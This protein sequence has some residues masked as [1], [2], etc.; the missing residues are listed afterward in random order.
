MCRPF[1]MIITPNDTLFN[2]KTNSH[3]DLIKEH[4]LKDDSKKPNFVRVEITPKDGDLFNHNLDNWVMRVDQ[5]FKPAWWKNK[6]KHEKHLKC[7]LEK[8]IFP[9]RFAINE[10]GKEFENA[11]VWIKN[12]KGIIVRNSS[13]VAW[14]NSS[15]VARGNS[16]VVAWENSS[17]VACVNSSVVAWENSSVVAWENSSVEARGNSSVVARE[18]SSVEAN[19]FSMIAV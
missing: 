17:V 11:S 12:S 13:V 2:L 9:K 16:S 18:N 7:I 1:S 19:D 5:D 6:D 15:V 8:E 14:E 3:E 4:E 10:D